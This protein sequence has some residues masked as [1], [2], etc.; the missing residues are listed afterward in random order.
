VKSIQIMS[1]T[2][3][4]ASLLLGSSSAYSQAVGRGE[5]GPIRALLSLENE[6]VCAGAA[7]ETG[8]NRGNRGQETGDRRDVTLVS[9][10]SGLFEE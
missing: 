8:G 9:L 6:T 2:L 10:H 1:S 7:R 4:A 3:L 5:K